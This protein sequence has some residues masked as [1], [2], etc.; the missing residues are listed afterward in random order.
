MA[1]STEI[2]PYQFEPTDV[3][4]YSD[5]DDASSESETD[6]REQASFTEHFG[7][8]DWCEC[9]KFLRMPSSIECQCCCEME[10][11]ADR[12]TD[13]GAS[14]Q[15]ITDHEQFKVVCLNKDILYTALVMMKS[16]C[17]DTLCVVI[18]CAFH[19]LTGTAWLKLILCTKHSSYCRSYRMA[20]YRQ[21]I[22]W[23]YH[24]LG[25]GIRKVIPS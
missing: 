3:S 2:K 13:D 11:I 25:R 17:G 7:T 18:H 14:L 12:L 20:A 9:A 5:D 16:E 24:R 6:I 22:Y 8:V 4:G 23:T 19:W 1:K 10:G 15:C 21:F